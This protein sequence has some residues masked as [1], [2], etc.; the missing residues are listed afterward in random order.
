M[1]HRFS[2]QGP[3]DRILLI[4]SQACTLARLRLAHIVLERCVQPDTTVADDRNERLE[5]GLRQGGRG[6]V[7]RNNGVALLWCL[8]G[9]WGVGSAHALPPAA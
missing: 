3:T 7:T 8:C 1:H 2:R 4:R 5:T 6:A 9:G